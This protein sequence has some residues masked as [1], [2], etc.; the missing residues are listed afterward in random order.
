M[1]TEVPAIEVNGLTVAYNATP[2]LWDINLSIPQRVVMGLVGPNGAGKSTLLKCA[3]GLV[4]KLAGEISILGKPLGADRK[5]IGYVPQRSAIDWDFPTTVL[6]LVTMGTYGR[7][8][9]FRRPGKR[10]KA[11]AMAA[12]ERL[13]M[14]DF[15]TRQI[16]ELSGGQQQR[17]F[18]ARAFVQDA[19]IY[20][21]DEPFAGVDI[22]TE[23]AI[24]GLLH[25]LRDA[26]KTIVVVQ[27]DLN[28]VGEYLDQ[29]TLINQQIISSGSVESAFTPDIVELTYGSPIRGI[30]ELAAEFEPSL[31]D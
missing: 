13:S 22:T 26:G 9:W 7:L 15:A 18:L 2:V 20:F 28:T 12:L 29:I 8:G 23:K 25:E 14:Q 4:P 17:A 30:S 21:L 19:P 11:D 1:K 3:L 10:E 31:S 5:Q 6:D 27:H 24:V 16:G